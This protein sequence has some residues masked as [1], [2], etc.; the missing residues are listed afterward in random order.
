[1]TPMEKKNTVRRP[2]Y[3]ML[4]SAAEFQSGHMPGHKGHA[5]F[6]MMDLYRLDTTELPSTDDL[7][8][9]ERGIAEAEILYAASAGAGTSIFLHNGSTSGIHVMLQLWAREGDTVLMPRNAHLSAMNACILG[10]LKPVWINVTRRSD[11]Y[12]YVRTE[13]VLSAIHAHPGAKALLLTRPDYYGGCIP[14]QEIVHAAHE[15]NIRVVVDEAHGAHLPWMDTI[16]SAGAC[17]ADAWTQSV[18]KT[19]P[20]FTASAVL[21][22]KHAEDREHAL[23]LLRR[24]QTS[25]PSF[26][27]MLSVDDARAWME[28]YGRERLHQTIHAANELRRRLQ[29]TPY[30]DAHDLWQKTGLTFDPT[31]LVLEAPE[32]GE[33]LA[34]RLRVQN[35]EVEMYDPWRVVIILTCMD[36][37]EEIRHL[38][39]V[40][41]SLPGETANLPTLQ[42]ALLLPRQVMTPRK[43]VMSETESIPLSQAAGRV[44]AVS[45]GL[46]PPGIP[47]VCP[48]EE[49]TEE[50]AKQLKQA[51]PQRRFGVEGDTILCVK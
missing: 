25:S 5:P 16:P 44:S 46:Y 43:A 49:I 10:G 45:A 1:M 42:Q 14:L 47:S 9:A 6:G 50:T 37:E 15:Q 29:T 4:T 19:L 7:Y 24:E 36:T 13:D 33:R 28:L 32:G 3:E 17:G 51:S 41:T 38:A 35:I 21:H 18:H 12:C 40:L 48:G 31:R 39:D 34:E 11:G 22:L 30:R 2:M 20:G 23:Q 8:T 27:L 26:L